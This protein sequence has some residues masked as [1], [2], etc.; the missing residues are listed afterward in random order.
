MNIYCADDMYLKFFLCTTTLRNCYCEIEIV[1]LV[2]YWFINM[3]VHL[4][5]KFKQVY[6]FNSLFIMLLPGTRSELMTL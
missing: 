3:S 2:N 6:F 4:L 5:H 1:T